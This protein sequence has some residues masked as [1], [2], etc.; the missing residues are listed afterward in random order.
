LSHYLE[1]RAKTRLFFVSHP[2]F[3]VVPLELRG[4]VKGRKEVFF[5]MQKNGGPVIDFFS[6]L[7]I[8]ENNVTKNRSRLY[9]TL[10][11][12]LEHV[13]RN[14]MKRYLLPFSTFT[15]TFPKCIKGIATRQKVGVRSYW[16]GK[17]VQQKIERGQLQLG[18]N[19]QKA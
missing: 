16:L 3:V 11:N 1:F 4:L 15:K 14:A 12:I 13:C 2:S 17:E 9:R 8:Q 19:V 5:I 6:S 18:I 7:E 10:Q